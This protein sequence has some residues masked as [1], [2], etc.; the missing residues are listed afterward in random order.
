MSRAR[1]TPMTRQDPS[2]PPPSSGV[3]G[4]DPGVTA[5]LAE[6]EHSLRTSGADAM[7]ERLCEA[8]RERRSPQALFEALMLR[9]R[10]RI[11][12]PP[13]PASAT[14]EIPPA[15]R[16]AYTAAIREAALAVGALCLEEGRIADAW[17]FY[18]MIG[19]PGP[20]AMAIEAYQPRDSG[21]CQRVV[22]IALEEG[23]NPRRGFDLVLEQFGLCAGITLLGSALGHDDDTRTHG[24]RRVV[25]AL[26][27]DLQRELTAAVAAREGGPGPRTEI[28]ELIDGRPWLFDGAACHVEPS[29]LATAVALARDLPGDPELGL[30]IDLCEYGT[31]LD[32]SLHPPG[33]PPF[34]D[35]YPDHRAYLR[36]VAGSAI[37]EGLAHFR[38]KL[39]DAGAPGESTRS[40]AVLVSLLARLGRY[41]EALAVFADHGEDLRDPALRCPSLEDLCRRAGDYRPLLA[42]ARCSDDLLGFAMGLLES[43][44][45]GAP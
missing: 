7:V 41:S 8:L 38:R 4:P 29:H 31:R 12:L 3:A 35:H 39:D 16:Q 34:Q 36:A 9:A 19:E 33:D 27:D 11:G 28:R 14:E 15:A 13:A 20:V 5:V 23:A 30:A 21:E 6:L 1:S 25:R 44:P 32:P 42:R 37:D 24:V 10:L 22:E 18:R 17:P 40:A 2:D 45:R 26:H 43:G